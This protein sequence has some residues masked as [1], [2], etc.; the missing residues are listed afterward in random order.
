MPEIDA[1]CE[2]AFAGPEDPISD[3]CALGFNQY[4]ST[5]AG[6][7]AKEVFSPAK[8]CQKIRLC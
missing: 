6:W 2:I 3:V 8:A 4:C 5:F 7:I 1:I